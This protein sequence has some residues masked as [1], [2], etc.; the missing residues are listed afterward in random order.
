M[1][2]STYTA[3]PRQLLGHVEGNTDQNSP[4]EV[5]LEDE[6]NGPNRGGAIMSCTFLCFFLENKYVKNQTQ[7]KGEVGVAINVK[8][9]PVLSVVPVD[10]LVILLSSKG[11][12][13][14]RTGK[15][16]L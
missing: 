5:G 11:L 16:K 13:I 14:S 3:D 8:N 6:I 4:L 15:E 9:P 12:W 2:V 1:G 10:N 7:P